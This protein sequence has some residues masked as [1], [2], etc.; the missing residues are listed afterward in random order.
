VTV[1]IRVCDESGRET[2][3]CDGRCHRA[4]PLKPSRCICGGLL[5]GC[6]RDGETALDVAPEFL[7]VVRESIKLKPGESVQLRIGA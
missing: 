2:R 5:R 4:D 1:L 3:R 6:E 7:A